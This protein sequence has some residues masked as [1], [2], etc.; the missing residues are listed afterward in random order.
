MPHTN[1]WNG[2]TKEAPKKK[3]LFIPKRKLT[4]EEKKERK[5]LLQ[6]ELDDLE[7]R[8][9]E[10]APP[11]SVLEFILSISSE[12]QPVLKGSQS[13]TINFANKSHNF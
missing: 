1:N 3:V 13:P 4:K 9:V 5:Q 10:E 12:V 8:I 6:K 7:R 11:R 2:H